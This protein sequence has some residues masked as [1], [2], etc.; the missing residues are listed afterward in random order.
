MAAITPAP[1]PRTLVVV[2]PD[3]TTTAARR[4][5]SSASWLSKRRRSPNSSSASS[6]RA[7][8]T[9]PAGSKATS[10]QA[11][12][13]AWILTGVAAGHE[14]QDDAAEAVGHPGTR[15]SEVL[16]PPGPQPHDFFAAWS[17]FV[18]SDK[19]FARGAATATEPFWGS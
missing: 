10:S 15:P 8:A 9:A 13:L 12:L 18:T 3:A 1:T 17:S 19:R 5:L 7:A 4:S 16:A 11:T 2:V 14:L 6:L